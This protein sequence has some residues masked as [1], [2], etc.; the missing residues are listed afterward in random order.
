MNK[1][2]L[3]SKATG[4]TL[5]EAIVSVVIL[6]GGIVIVAQG[7]SGG[8][9]GVMRAQQETI[10]ATLAESQ[11]ALIEAEQIDL[12][13]NSQGDCGNAYPAYA[14]RTMVTPKEYDKLVQVDLEIYWIDRNE[15]RSFQ[16]TRLIN[17]KDKEE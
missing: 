17:L 16:V 15:E 1:M 5:V 8:L 2:D 7:F 14:W 12:S 11:M 6:V 3:S 4:F 13:Q 9:R 10:A